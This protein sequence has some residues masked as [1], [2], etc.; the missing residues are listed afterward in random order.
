MKHIL[1]TFFIMVLHLLCSISLYAQADTKGTDFWLAFPGRGSGVANLQIRIVG[2]SQDAKFTIHFTGTNTT[3]VEDEDIAAG[4][5]YTHNLSPQEISALQ[6]IETGITNR[7]VHITSTS[8]ITIYALHAASYAACDATNILPTTALGTNYYQ[9]SYNGYNYGDSYTVVA[10]KNNTQVHHDDTS[11]TLHEGEVYFYRTSS[12]SINDDLTGTYITSDKPIALFATNNG[13]LIPA[14]GGYTMDN[15]FQQLAPVNTWGK[16]FFVPVSHQSRDRVRIMVSQNNTKIETSGTIITKPEESTLSYTDDG[17]PIISNINA[18]EWVELEVSLDN[19]G[20]YIK[21]DKPIGVCTYL[22]CSSY[23]PL[24]RESDPSQAWLPSIEQTVKSALVAPFIPST[25]T[26]LDTHY[27]LIITPT[28]TKNNTI[29]SVGG[30]S[31]TTLSGGTW[32]DNID[33]GLSFYSLPLIDPTASYI[34]TNQDGLIIMG[35]GVGIDVSYYYLA[36]SAMR[37]LDAAF[38]IN[39]VH[40]QDFAA[41]TFCPGPY[42]FRAEINGDISTSAGHLKWYINE[43]EELSARDRQE[44]SKPL[45]NGAYKIKMVVLMDD[46]VTTKTVESDL[47]VTSCQPEQPAV[48]TIGT[49]I[50]RED[51]GG[52]TLFTPIVKPGGISSVPSFSD[53]G[54]SYNHWTNFIIPLRIHTVNIH[55]LNLLNPFSLQAGDY[56]L[57]KK[58]KSRSNIWYEPT[59]HTHPGSPFRGYLMQVNGSSRR[60]T[61]YKTRLDACPGSE[62]R[63]SFWGMSLMRSKSDIYEPAVL[64]LAINGEVKQTIT[65]ENGQGTWERFEMTYQ[66]PS[67]QNSLVFEIINNNPSPNSSVYG[68]DFALD[69]IE[70]RMCVPDVEIKAPS[71]LCQG[72]PFEIRYTGNADF[73]GPTT[74]QWYKSTSGNVNSLSGWTPAGSGQHLQ[75]QSASAEEHAGY[76]RLEVTD[77]TGSCRSMSDPVYVYVMDC[78]KCESCLSSFAPVPGEKYVLSAWV[79]ETGHT[80]GE[81]DELLVTGYEN[82][83]IVLTFENSGQEIGAMAEGAVIDGW[84]RIYTEF[85]VPQDAVTMKIELANTGMGSSFFDDIRVFPLNGNMKSYVYDPVTM[86][87]VAELDNEN[88]AT[89]YEYDEEGSLIRVKKETEKGV[90]T[91]REARQAKPEKE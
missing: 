81:E 31:A 8:P 26:N 64:E 16:N 45:T 75:I 83:I 91:I 40:Y 77:G 39:D 73:T 4:Q 57:V 85:T 90:M 53:G 20:C 34:I 17:K 68:N 2:G 52:N 35:Y 61:C 58:G 7:S 10:T 43:V 86:R 42:E 87:L 59:D 88:Y 47:T 63:F 62:L 54:L 82:S 37:S 69:D 66:V 33:A 72:K 67:G 25:Q 49:L 3:P 22:T 13:A 65:L 14:V 19:N 70:V 32:Y 38:Y 27:V 76:Y 44:W 24:D 28:A 48:C 1:I 50:F 6:S 29:V 46:D 84:Q 74:Y 51:F 5:V 80:G 71:S 41:E 11:V 12:S 56:S 78:N 23:N 30:A 15:L 21:A 9:I 89:F 79:K 18:G 60:N 36:S 55:Q